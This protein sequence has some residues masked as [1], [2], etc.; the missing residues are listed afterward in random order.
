MK[1]AFILLLITF[2]CFESKSQ[3]TLRVLSYNILNF[4]TS[5]SSKA[6]TLKAIIKY[7]QPDI[8]LVTELTSSVG[9]SL[10]LNDAL[11]VDGVTHYQNVSYV[12]GP[13]SDNLIFFNS[14]KF[15]F[16][17]R[18][19]IPTVLRNISE[20]VLYYKSPNLAV[21][22]DT[23]YLHCYVA[24]LKASNSSADS[25]QRNQEAVTFK[26]Y[27][28]SKTQ[29]VTNILL[30]GDFNVYTSNEAAYNT[31]LNGGNVLLEDP[32]NSP[33]NWQANS[34][35]S[36]IHTQST[37]TAVL[38]DG[39]SVGGLDDRFDF[40]F[41]GQ[42]VM[43]G[44]NKIKY[45]PGTYQAI[46]NDGLH[47]NKSILASPTNNSV[48][49]NVLEALYY[50]SDHLPVFAKLYFDEALST[51]EFQLE[52][53]W[54]GYYTNN[55]FVF[56]TKINEKQLEFQLFDVLGKSVAKKTFTNLNS[57]EFDYGSLQTGLYFVKVWNAN[58]QLKT[59]R[60]V[61]Q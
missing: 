48:P 4:P 31:I 42:D 2:F 59:F 27:L 55:T 16:I 7:T 35:F 22:Q 39:G 38:S 57:F 15:G 26:N 8:F 43:Q 1:H 54:N 18:H 24:H 51:N 40:I 47:F 29:P 25:L 52:N 17:S 41:M 36:S 49:N 61:K 56:K 12:N 53:V 30:G 9:A 60:I 44:T 50:M 23:T 13:D 14:D 33:G 21:T 32:I 34:S 11:N 28:D 5:N 6:D 10:I 37:R 3:D 46:G 20:Y 19:E 45:I 58:Q